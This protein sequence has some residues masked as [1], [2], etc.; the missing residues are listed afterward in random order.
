MENNA[1]QID[2]L[3]GT[4]IGGCQLIEVIGKGSMGVVYKGKHVG[5]NKMVA[6]KLIPVAQVDEES[7]KRF[8]AEARS[9]AKLEHQNIAQ[10]YNVGF[11]KGFCFIILQ[12]LTGRS[13][14][15]ILQERRLLPAD[16]TLHVVRAI[17]EGLAVAHAKGIIH[18][19][20]K[21]D[22]VMI[23]KEGIVKITDFGLAHDIESGDGAKVIAGTPHYMSPEQWLGHPVD[24]RSDLYALGVMAYFM[25][26][27]KRPF[28][29]ALVEDIMTKH[30][31]SVPPSPTEINSAVPESVSAVVK[32]LITKS[33]AKRYQ[34][35]RELAKDIELIQAGV[36]P[37]A[38]EDFERKKRC[39]FCDTLNNAKLSRCQVCNEPLER[40]AKISELSF[41]EREGEFTCPA[42]GEFL[43]IG[44][45]AC[46]RCGVKFCEKC[47]KEVAE[48]GVLCLSCAVFS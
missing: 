1:R 3:A 46:T 28:E 41:A 42:C 39:S 40:A 19:D 33:P 38:M 12:L 34:N 31:Q 45:R 21:P 4:T 14:A 37:Q 9:A 18:R 7:V 48:K 10:V 47:R 25:L 43:R 32:K 29:G 20:L 23:T 27:G 35:C 15:A 36:E 22:N 26:T 16:K 44:I 17:V 5:L 24:G 30:L 2:K 8:L 6:I 11:E 13:L